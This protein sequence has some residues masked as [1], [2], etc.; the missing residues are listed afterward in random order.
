MF[1]FGFFR[2]FCFLEAFALL[3]ISFYCFTG[4]DEYEKALT[5]FEIVR[6]SK[7]LLK[8]ELKKGKVG[9]FYSTSFF[10]A[11]SMSFTVC[12]RQG[13]NSLGEFGYVL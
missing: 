2:L 3:T 10:L 11:S 5:R 1:I 12:K 8:S 9:R 4:F 6:T 13:S 7:F